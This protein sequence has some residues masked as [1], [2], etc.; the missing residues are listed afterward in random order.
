MSKE[1]S[2]SII[3][4]DS[5][6]ILT[7]RTCATAITADMTFAT[8]SAADFR[9]EYKNIEFL[10]KQR[11][12]IRGVAALPPAALQV[13]WKY[14]CFLVT[15]VRDKQRVDPEGLDLFLTKLRDFL[16]ER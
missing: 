6:F 4:K 1:F 15:R 11:P 16:L 9:R 8:A 12:G 14:L 5:D 10:W 3:L 7:D 13:P 2:S